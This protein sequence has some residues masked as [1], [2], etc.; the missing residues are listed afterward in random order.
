MLE[1][2]VVQS[3]SPYYTLS[4]SHTHIT[5]SLTPSHP[6]T[7]T[8]SHP[9][10]LTPSHPHSLTP[11]QAVLNADKKRVQLL[12]EEAAL[13]AE[14]EA[15]DDTNSE[16]LKQVCIELEAIGAASAEARARRILA[17]SH[18]PFPSPSSL[19]ERLL[20]IP[21]FFLSLPPSLLYIGPQLHE[22]DAGESDKEV[23]WRMEDE[24]FT[25]TVIAG[26]AVT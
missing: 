13:T 1:V 18:S 14:A 5:N 19:P 16:R 2:V 6:H 26:L 3:T 4:S 15:G 23:L 9:H 17:V 11:T 12:A 20:L 8:P 22:G 7:F 25:C 21:N 10:T 24:S